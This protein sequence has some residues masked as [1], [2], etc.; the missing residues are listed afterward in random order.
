VD[1]IEA[2][3]IEHGI[4][5][6]TRTTYPAHPEMDVAEAVVGLLAAAV[7]HEAKRAAPE[8]GRIE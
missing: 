5:S 1:T 4:E 3:A 8:E 6:S 7:S 2:K